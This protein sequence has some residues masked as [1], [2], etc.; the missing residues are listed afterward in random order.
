MLQ[1]KIE[2]DRPE[3]VMGILTSDGKTTVSN[4]VFAWCHVNS[5]GFK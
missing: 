5:N 1:H 2:V 4:K 3:A